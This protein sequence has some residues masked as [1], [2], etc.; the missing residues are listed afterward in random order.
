MNKLRASHK[1]EHHASQINYIFVL[2]YF[3]RSVF[4]E[5]RNLSKLLYKENILTCVCQRVNHFSTP[6][7]IV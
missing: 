4:F 6:T 1:A 7:L 2:R 5:L 3:S